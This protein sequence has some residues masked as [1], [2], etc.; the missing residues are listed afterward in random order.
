MAGIDRRRCGVDYGA[1]PERKPAMANRK[2]SSGS[3]SL[4]RQSGLIS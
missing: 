3:K 4:Q 1:Y 2:A